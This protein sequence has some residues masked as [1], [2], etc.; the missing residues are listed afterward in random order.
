ML[1]E[2]EVYKWFRDGGD[3]N[4]RLSYDLNSESIFF[5]LGGYLGNY[6][7]KI[8]DKFNP[9]SYIFEPSKE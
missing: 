1:L 4:L 2:Y 8:L 6:T 5:E 7:K 9:V 3:E